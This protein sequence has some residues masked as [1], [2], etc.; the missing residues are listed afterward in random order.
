MA[1]CWPDWLIAQSKMLWP[2]SISQKAIGGGTVAYLKGVNLSIV[3]SMT[4][5]IPRSKGL[6]VDPWVTV[7]VNSRSNNDSVGESAYSKDVM[8]GPYLDSASN[9][10]KA[11]PDAT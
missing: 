5:T 11:V 6:L 2:S 10:A 9:T 7:K 8:Y 1:N 4:A 3:P